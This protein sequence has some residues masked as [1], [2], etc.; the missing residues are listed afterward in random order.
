MAKLG[1]FFTALKKKEGLTLSLSLI[2]FFIGVFL[3]FKEYFPSIDVS[4]LSV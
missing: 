2:S 4:K 3:L 1:K